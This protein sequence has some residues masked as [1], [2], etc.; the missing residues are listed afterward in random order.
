MTKNKLTPILQLILAIVVV[1]L[2]GFCSSLWPATL[3]VNTP[4]STR[5]PCRRRAR[6][7]V[8]SGSC[9]TCSWALLFFWFYGPTQTTSLSVQPWGSL[10]FS[11][12][13]TFCGVFS[14][15][16]AA[17]SGW[18]PSSSC[19]WTRRSLPASSGLEKSPIWPRASWFPTSS[20]FCS[21]PI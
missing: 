7:S 19:F 9:S 20:G 15:S 10:S 1:E 6:C 2:V 21:P 17:P 13:L 12:F 14:F 18:R 5:R 11:C 8:R 3:P 4:C 16:A